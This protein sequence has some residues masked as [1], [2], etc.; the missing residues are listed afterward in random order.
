MCMFL[1]QASASCA[2]CSILSASCTTFAVWVPKKMYRISVNFVRALT[3]LRL[4]CSF[5]QVRSFLSLQGTEHQNFVIRIRL[6]CDASKFS[7]PY[8]V[9]R[10]DVN[11]S[12]KLDLY[13]ISEQF[14]GQFSTFSHG[15]YINRQRDW[16][17]Q[18]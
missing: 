17:N 7:C 10:I 18:L 9:G 5:W 14:V 1:F 15:L 13:Q 11:I 2:L 16:E 8:S 4:Y 12:K 6:L 3:R